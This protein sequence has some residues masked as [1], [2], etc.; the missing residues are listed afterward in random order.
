ME[1]TRLC[2]LPQ[3]YGETITHYGYTISTTFGTFLLLVG[4]SLGILPAPRTVYQTSG[5]ENLKA[6]EE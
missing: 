2:F 4:M 6:W 5:E 1:M 3:Y